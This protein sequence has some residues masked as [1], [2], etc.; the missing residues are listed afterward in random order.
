MIQHRGEMSAQM[1]TRPIRILIVD[2][3]PRARDSMR[4]LLSTCNGIAE[5]RE[6]R[7]GR[8]AVDLVGKFQPDVVLI[9]VRMPEIDGL[10]ATLLMKA[11]WPQVKVVALSLY[12]EHRQE[13]LAAGADA[14]V[15]KADAWEKLLVTVEELINEM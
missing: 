6:A 7:N 11:L 8:E 9:D 14:F 1:T 3:Q 12:P 5:V 13:A 2:D 10:K 4:A 15:A